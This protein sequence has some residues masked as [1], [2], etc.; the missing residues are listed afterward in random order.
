MLC[1]V[2]Q[3]LVK[4]DEE[5]ILSWLGKNLSAHNNT[6]LDLIL[7]ILIYEMMKEP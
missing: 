4:S 2:Q 6:T 7:R 3:L 1:R 5:A